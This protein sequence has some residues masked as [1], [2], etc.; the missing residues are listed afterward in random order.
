MLLSY[1]LLSVDPGLHG[2]GLLPDN[3]LTYRSPDEISALYSMLDSLLIR[4]A[5]RYNR[6]VAVRTTHNA[7][8]KALVNVI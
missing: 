6:M 8:Q 3:P 1:L 7:A 4:P 5:S 2:S